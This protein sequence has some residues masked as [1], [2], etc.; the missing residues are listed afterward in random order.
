MRYSRVIRT[1]SLVAALSLANAAYAADEDAAAGPKAAMKGLFEAIEAADAA[2]VRTQ[3]NAATPEEKALADAYADQITAAKSLGEAAKAKFGAT[4]DPLTKGMPMKDSIAQL[5][6]ADV[7]V[8]GNQAT[9]KLPGQPRSVRLT[10][11][12]G[13]WRVDLAD[14][15]G[16]TPENIAGQTA[17]LRDMSQ[18]LRSIATDIAADKFISPADAQRALNQKLQGVLFNTLQKHPPTSRPVKP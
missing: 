10:K 13:K 16:A 7:S 4:G 15:A 12:D 6:K 8:T 5:D 14:Y 2:A 18:A 1:F 9:V 3:F 11:I 17:V